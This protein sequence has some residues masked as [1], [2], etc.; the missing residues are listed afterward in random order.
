MHMHVRARSN[1]AE[2]ELSDNKLG[3]AV[4]GAVFQLHSLSFLSLAS[5]GL[6]QLGPE[7]GQLTALRCGS[8]MNAWSCNC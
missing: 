8:Y 5:N 6:E 7:V 4:P 3:P 2:L 1:L